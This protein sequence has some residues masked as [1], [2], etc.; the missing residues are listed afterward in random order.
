MIRKFIESLKEFK[1]C[2]EYTYKLV[3]AENE[4]M[5]RYIQNMYY[6]KSSSIPFICGEAGDKGKDN[7]PEYLFICPGYGQAGYA[8]Y[9][10]ERDYSEP[11]Y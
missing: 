8:V 7:M 4:K 10:K 3:E 5:K 11:G 6:D 9:K 1:E 2:K